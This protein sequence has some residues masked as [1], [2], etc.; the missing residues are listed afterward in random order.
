MVINMNEERLGT[1]EQIE[2]FLSGSAAIEFSVAGDDSER[3]GHISC[4][5]QRFD[6]PQ[7]SKR[8][9]ATW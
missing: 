2:D 6:H 1:I 3:Y 8:C 7:R 4:V 5:L 9:I